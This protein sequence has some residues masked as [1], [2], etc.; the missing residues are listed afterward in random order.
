MQQGIPSFYFLLR[1]RIF[2]IAGRLILKP[3]QSCGSFL[4]WS[5]G[6]AWT[7][8]FVFENCV[9]ALIHLLARS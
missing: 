7:A 3:W 5:A 8:K 1:R 9:M 2:S 4:R 6:Y